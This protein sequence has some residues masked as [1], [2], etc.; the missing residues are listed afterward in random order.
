MKKLLLLSLLSINL[1]ANCIISSVLLEDSKHYVLQF[2]EEDK[3]NNCYEIVEESPVIEFSDIP[4]FV[5]DSSIEECILDINSNFS[6]E[7]CQS[8]LLAAGY[9]SNWFIENYILPLMY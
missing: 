8:E 6:F 5:L 1:N 4:Y 2:L 7:F 3:E 9:Y